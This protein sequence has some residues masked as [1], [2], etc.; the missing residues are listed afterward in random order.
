MKEDMKSSPESI[1]QQFWELISQKRF[2]WIFGNTEKHSEEGQMDHLV[3]RTRQVLQAAMNELI[4]EK[5]DYSAFAI[6]DI[7]INSFFSQLW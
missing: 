2:Y 6:S 3:F 1:S 7:V 4:F 5:K